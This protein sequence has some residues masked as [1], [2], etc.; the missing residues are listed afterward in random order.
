MGV[1]RNLPL[2]RARKQA[3]IAGDPDRIA[4]QKKLNKLTARERIE[5]LVDSSSFVELDALAGRD[6]KAGVITG[7]GLIDGRPV[8]VYA[9]D[10]TSM[11]GAVGMDHQRK[12]LKV[13]DLA[14]KTGLPVLAIMDSKGARLTEG[15]DAVNAYAQIAAKTAMLSG[16]V[17]QIALVLGECAGSAATIAAMNDVVI[18]ADSTRLFVNG[19]QVVEANTGKQVNAA[20][21][22]NA[23]DCMKSGIAQLVAKTDAEAIALARSVISFFPGNNLEDAPVDLSEPDVTDRLIPDFDEVSDARSVISA[24]ADNGRIVEF[25]S[26]YAADMVTALARVAGQTVGFIATQASSN[27]G[28]LTVDGCAKAARFVRMMDC[29]NIPVVSLVDT[30]GMQI[31]SDAGQAALARAGAQ[32]TFA[33]SEA[34]TARIALIIGNAIGAGYMALASRASADMVYAWPGS[35][36][37]PLAAPAAV[38]VLM[39]EKLK[40]AKDG[41][42]EREA[43]E[44]DYQDNIADGLNA[45]KLGYVDDVIEPS[46]TRIMLISA[47]DMLSS[48]RDARPAKK[49]GNLPL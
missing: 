28:S 15:V 24:L 39:S 25:S 47:L 13:M 9:Q 18:V 33:L 41:Q 12:V 2:V 22:G 43:L 46:K 17:P 27:E 37:A 34:T 29:F 20:K 44:K 48:K 49:H 19:P 21:F 5:L 16:V 11:G 6:G 32:L 26:A 14:Q 36:I 1:D 3:I 40:A 7:Y 31:T 23:A 35:V 38:Q 42:V 10:Y 4:E 30:I 45:A 8:Y